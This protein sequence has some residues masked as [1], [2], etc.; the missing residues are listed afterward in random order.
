PGFP[1]RWC[2]SLAPVLAPRLEALVVGRAHTAGRPLATRELV[3]PVAKFAPGDTTATA[4]REQLEGAIAALQARG[5]RAAD[6]GW[7][8]P[9]ELG[10][11]IGR[12]SALAWPQLANRVLPGLGLGLAADDKSKLVDQDAWAAAIVARAL[13]LWTGG[14][15]PSLAAVCDALVW[16]PLRLPA[17]PKRRPPELRALFVRRELRA[18]PQRARPRSGPPEEARR[19][20]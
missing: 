19:T 8:D 6:H 14:P 3:E 13:G 15:P 18:P 9:A 10:R 16:R 7:L 5:V 12:T 1:A 4:W 2:S 11:L 20:P 17:K